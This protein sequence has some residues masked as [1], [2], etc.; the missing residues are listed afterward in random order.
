[1]HHAWTAGWRERGRDGTIN[2]VCGQILRAFR[3]GAGGAWGHVARRVHNTQGACG[4]APPP[5]PAGGAGPDLAAGA[6]ACLLARAWAP[7]L[8]RREG[9]RGERERGGWQ[10]YT[11]EILSRPITAAL[12]EGKVGGRE[13][14]IA[15]KVHLRCYKQSW[16]Q[17][18]RACGPHD[19]TLCMAYAAKGRG[20]RAAR[21][22]NP[23]N[24][25]G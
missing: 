17:R 12:I 4:P 5:G 1:M 15:R 22:R 23:Y 10:R 7:R 14:R 3:L 2:F 11:V 13:E 8:C 18:L 16:P 24:F 21:V 19:D 9:S 6:H 25:S 20:R